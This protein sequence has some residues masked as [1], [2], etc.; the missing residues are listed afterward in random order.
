MSQRIVSL[1]KKAPIVQQSKKKI[2]STPV[3]LYYAQ[4]CE[5]CK[6]LIRILIHVPMLSKMVKCINVNEYEVDP[7][8]D[9]IPT[10][11]EGNDDRGNKLLHKLENAFN[12]ILHQCYKLVDLPPDQYPE[13]PTIEQVAEIEI[14]V[15]RVFYD[16]QV[17]MSGGKV[18]DKNLM[19]Y[20]V[21]DDNPFD[22]YETIAGHTE[23]SKADYSGQ[24][25]TK[26]V[27]KEMLKAAA[28]KPRPRGSINDRMQTYMKEREQQI[29][30][31]KK[32]WERDGTKPREPTHVIKRSDLRAPR[33]ISELELKD[34]EAQ[35]LQMLEQLPRHERPAIREPLKRHAI[36]MG[37][38]ITE[39]DIQD[40]ELKKQKM[41]ENIRSRYNT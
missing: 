34:W 35:R 41:M 5:F 13:K 28:A 14:R 23:L 26:E 15:K 40:Y 27:Y 22:Q 12:W 2:V 30:S 3:Y 29:E 11:D 4:D 16:L 38:S 1:R 39:K 7:A 18:R 36:K 8:I 9:S 37:T 24:Y 32:I 19:K 31:I 25:K 10:I 17:M 20:N 33:M 6:E 21:G